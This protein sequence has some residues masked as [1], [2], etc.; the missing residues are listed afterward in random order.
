[1]ALYFVGDVQGCYD[2]LRQLL[3][4]AGFSQDEDE[5]WLTGDLVARGPKSLEV[6]RYVTSL[7]ERATTV[8][9]NHDLHLLATAAGYAK[10]KKKDQLEALLN[11]PDATKLLRWLRQHPLLAL[12]F[13]AMTLLLILIPVLNFLAMPAAVVGATLMWN[14]ELSDSP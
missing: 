12:G 8:L 3:D 10:P 13:G 5:L 4:L 7:G 9:G 2:E 11:A 6:L 1:M 14:K